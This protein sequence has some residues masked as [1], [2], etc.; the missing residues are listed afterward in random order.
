MSPAQRIYLMTN[1]TLLNRSLM[2]SLIRAMSIDIHIPCAS[3]GERIIDLLLSGHSISPNSLVWSNYAFYLPHCRSMSFDIQ[4]S[5]EEF[6]ARCLDV[7]RTPPH[8]L[9]ST[10]KSSILEVGLLKGLVNYLS[11][12]EPSRCPLPHLHHLSINYLNCDP[13]CLADERFRYLELPSA[14]TDLDI[15]YTFDERTPFCFLEKH[16]PKAR[17]NSLRRT[18]VRKADDS[19]HETIPGAAKWVLPSVERLTVTGA[20]EDAVI[21]I[22]AQCP[23]LTNLSSDADI[24][25]GAEFQGVG[26]HRVFNESSMVGDETTTTK[27][28]CPHLSH[29]VYEKNG[30]RKRPCSSRKFKYSRI[31]VVRISGWME[32]IRYR[33]VL[34]RDVSR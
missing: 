10:P 28:C 31:F 15:T 11:D 13:C 33:P 34:L 17:W 4:N 29:R 25:W 21:S 14:I 12:C 6:I 2:K 16:G 5:P 18:T 23:K 24:N 32:R 30:K 9:D 26:F 3:Y 1:W 7:C 20:C 19:R 22:A 8:N 27:N